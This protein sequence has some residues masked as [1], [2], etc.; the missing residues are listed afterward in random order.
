MINKE[1]LLD[2][3]KEIDSIPRESGNENKIANYLVK[4]AKD[5]KLEVIKDKYNNVLISKVKDFKKPI[6]ILQ[7]H[8]DMVCE[9][10]SKSLHN[11]KKDPI[12]I[13]NENNLLRAFDTS[14]GADDGVA[15]SYM[16]Y[17]LDS[18]ITNIECLFTVQEEIG[19]VGANYFDYT[20]LHGKYLI[21]LDNES[22][23]DL[24]IGCAGGINLVYSKDLEYK[25]NNYQAYKLSLS[26]LS[27]RPFRCGY[28]S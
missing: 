17:L 16:L 21:N 18:D 25:D 22:D 10:T 28:W 19:L 4:F 27:G 14:L 11:F 12:K 26:N 8:T 5:R 2:Y 13:I 1:K 9:K 7:G 24:I 3:F 6:I 23:K 15:V 20:L